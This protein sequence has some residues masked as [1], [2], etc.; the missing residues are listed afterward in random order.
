MRLPGCEWWEYL[1][2][3]YDTG[4]AIMKIFEGDLTTIAPPQRPHAEI[5]L[6]GHIQAITAT[7]AI[8]RGTVIAIEVTILDRKG[9]LM[10]PWVRTCTCLEPGNHIPG[11]TG[12]RLDGPWLRSS[13]FTAT[14][15]DGRREVYVATSRGRLNLPRVPFSERVEPRHPFMIPLPAGPPSPGVVLGDPPAE[16]RGSTKDMPKAGF[17][18]PK[19]RTRG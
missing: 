19:T 4:A 9:K 16:F 5:K 8:F 12:H 7:S 14:V 15:P 6:M 11:V 10:T 13:L 3:I 17:R 18:V 2:M 1:D